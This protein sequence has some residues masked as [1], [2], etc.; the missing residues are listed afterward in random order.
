[1]T[2]AAFRDLAWQ[3]TRIQERRWLVRPRLIIK[4]DRDALLQISLA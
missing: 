3:W 4:D 1:M 2:I